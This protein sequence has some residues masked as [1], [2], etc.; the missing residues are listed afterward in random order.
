M[1][2]GKLLLKSFGCQMNKLDSS[3]VTAALQQAGYELTESVREADVVLINTCS[4]R[5]HAEDRVLSNLGHLKHLK[6]TRPE[7]V[8]AVIGCMAQRLGNEL[9]RHPAVDL[10]AGPA[11][12]PQVPDLIARLRDQ[13]EK[14]LAV[15]ADIRRPVSEADDQ[16]LDRFEQEYDSD[17]NP[18]PGQAF[19]R[20]MR[21][22]NKFCSYCVVPYVRGPEQSRSAG[23]IV[24]QAR[25]LA[26]RGI[27]Q[28]TLLGQTV[29]S[30]KH[31]EGDRT[32][33]LVDLIERISRIDGIHWIR[34]ITSHPHPFDERIFRAMADNPK[35]CRYLHIPAQSG[36]DRILKAMN[37]GYT[38]DEYIRLIDRARQIVPDLAVAGDFIVGFPGETDEDFE[39]TCELVRQ[40]RY[41]T[42]FIFKYSPRPGTRADQKLADSVPEEVKKKRNITLLDLQNQISEQDNPRFIGQSVEIFVE[43]PSKNPHLNA[44]EIQTLPQLVGR[45]GSDSIVVFTGPATL[46]GTFQS[47]RITKTS[48]LTL[49]GE[50]ISTFKS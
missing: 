15:T 41:K 24:E 25:K 27:R 33:T 34:F 35:I 30:Y 50:L 43:G 22:C 1:N 4:V 47:V 8:V 28:V 18:L 38:A 16:S 45:T 13:H 12:L 49:F 32:I 39:L 14:V 21:G 44:S 3:L 26:D 17:A 36:S 37:R 6:K 29:N 46:A 11:Q 10:V 5:G 23:A 7:L 31:A 2:R 9:L 20:I 48:A 40:I 19:I 42:C